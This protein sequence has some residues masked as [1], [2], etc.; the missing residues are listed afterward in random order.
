MYNSNK[1]RK[2]HNEHLIYHLIFDLPT[3]GD[4][5]MA[6]ICGYAISILVE[7]LNSGLSYRITTALAKSNDQEFCGNCLLLCN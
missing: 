3:I 5:L 7:N 2:T 6:N 1:I 4:T